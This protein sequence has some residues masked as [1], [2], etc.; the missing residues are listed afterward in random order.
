MAVG[1]VGQVTLTADPAWKPQPKFQLGYS[2]GLDCFFASGLLLK[3][4]TTKGPE[5]AQVHCTGTTASPNDINN[6]EWVVHFFD[7]VGK[8]TCLAFGS[9]PAGRIRWPVEVWLVTQDRLRRLFLA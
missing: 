4:A 5:S 1:P 3:Q 7:A 9:A 6:L 8:V 2:P